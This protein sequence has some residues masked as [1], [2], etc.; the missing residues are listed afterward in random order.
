MSE[1]F[2]CD[3][4]ETL[5]A[6]LYGEIDPSVR[7]EVERHLRTCAACTHEIEGL[8]A[9]RRDLQTWVPP[10]PEFGLTIGARTAPGAAVLTSSRWTVLREVPVWARVAAAVLVAGVSLGLANVQVRSNAD[11]FVVTTGWM[12][13]SVSPASAPGAST[14]A[15]VSPAPTPARAPIAADAGAPARDEWRRELAALERTLRTELAAERAAARQTAGP[16]RAAEAGAETNALL[17]RVQAMITAS[18]ERQRQEFATKFIQADH[19]WNVRRQTDLVNVQ[20][21]LGTLQNRT[22]AVQAN[23]QE[24]INQ[25][26]RVSLVT[27]NQ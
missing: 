25:L 16:V 12:T 13:P 24:A 9:V 22:I 6:Y 23:Q 11:G 3:D 1:V 17:R 8:Q 18:E 14:A 15:A 10:E 26:R 21:T 2:R 4:K 20:R 5:V 19:F 7:R 27:P